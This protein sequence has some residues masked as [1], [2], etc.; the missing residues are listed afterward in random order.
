MELAILYYRVYSLTISPLYTGQFV[1]IV[2]II[3]SFRHLS[4]KLHDV[5][6]HKVK[7]QD[8]LTQSTD[9]LK[10]LQ[11]MGYGDVMICFKSRL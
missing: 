10:A 5:D 2:R 4:I 6:K 3:P 9:T 7:F 11:K 1:K 8:P